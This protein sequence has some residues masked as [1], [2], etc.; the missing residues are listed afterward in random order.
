MTY[1]EQTYVAQVVDQYEKRFGDVDEE[2][3]V[4]P[5]PTLVHVPPAP[6][7][8][9]RRK[10]N[11]GTSNSEKKPAQKKELDSDL[12]RVVVCHAKG[13]C[14]EAEFNRLFGGPSPSS[15]AL[16]SCLT[17]KRPLPCSSCLQ[18]LP[19][20]HPHRPPFRLLHPPPD[21]YDD[22][23]NVLDTPPPSPPPSDR[24][25]ANADDD[26]SLAK[27]RAGLTAKQKTAASNDLDA[28]CMRVWATYSGSKYRHLPHTSLI[29]DK[30]FCALLDNFHLIRDREML[31][32]ICT[33]WPSADEHLGELFNVIKASNSIF[34]EERQEANAVKAQKAKAT[35]EKNAQSASGGTCSTRLT[36]ASDCYVL[37]FGSRIIA[38]CHRKQ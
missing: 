7:T 9:S 19:D 18:Q 8:P 25:D 15:H 30:T 38:S 34:D 23:D 28:F 14:L 32:N 26:G 35:R 13:F 36:R 2:E 31:A 37:T 5:A 21:F 6:L 4:L 10:V 12:W 16:A 3:D 1:V 20:N 24:E 33:E 11:H 29:P 17:A 27:K 22:D